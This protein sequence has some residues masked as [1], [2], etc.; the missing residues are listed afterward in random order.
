MQ[1]QVHADCYTESFKIG[2]SVN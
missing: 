2:T 1:F